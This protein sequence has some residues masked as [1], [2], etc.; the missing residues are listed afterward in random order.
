M[1]L[2][3]V[4]GSSAA[5]TDIPPVPQAPKLSAFGGA[6]YARP[7]PP[8]SH[9]VDKSSGVATGNR[10]CGV[11]VATRNV[12]QPVEQS[13]AVGAPAELSPPA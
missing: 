9:R 3:P 12:G 8:P 2:P 7:G 10:T 11:S 4:Q 1:P 6:D 13:T 5:P